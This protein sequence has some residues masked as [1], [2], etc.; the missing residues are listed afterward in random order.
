VTRILLV[1]HLSDSNLGDAAIF[2]GTAR[3]L[4]RRRPEAE[5]GVVPGIPANALLERDVRLSRHERM[6]VHAPICMPPVREVSPE[7]GVLLVAKAGF[8]IVRGTIVLGLARLHPR[9]ASIVL[10]PMERKTL[11]AFRNA[12][13]VILAG[14]SYLRAEARASHVVHVWRVMFPVLL[15][16]ALRRPVIGLGHSIGPI[17][18]GIAGRLLVW[19]L[20]RN[21]VVHVRDRFSQTLL[22]Q[23]T[24]RPAPWVPDCALGLGAGRA[25]PMPASPHERHRVGISVRPV[26]NAD[27]VTDA[28]VSMLEAV[29]PRPSEV[30]VF[31]NATG[32]SP[33]QDDRPVV[34]RLGEELRRRGLTV[35]TVELHDLD[36]ALECYR[37]CDVVVGV[38]MH[39]SILARLAGTPSLPIEYEGK[40]AAGVFQY[41]APG[42]R[43]PGLETGL[44]DRLVRSVEDLA[45]DGLAGEQRAALSKSI[46]TLERTVDDLVDALP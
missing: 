32:P 45:R 34:A 30:V 1:G 6:T 9:A 5:I 13:L 31:A 20:R 2:A 36:E 35:E 26:A 28:L 12:D 19:G 14:G 3:L 11:Q 27:R 21:W 8:E 15:G 43:V 38:R 42:T 33:K 16:L 25:D 24:H 10:T 39:A 18:P 37:E 44:G 23:V 22:E 17:E 29:E 46:S 4:R 41:L 40:K 7:K